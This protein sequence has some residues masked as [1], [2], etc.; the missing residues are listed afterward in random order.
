MPD[1]RRLR[2]EE[3]LVSALALLQ[4]TGVVANARW[5][6]YLAIIAYF[7]FT[8]GVGVFLRNKMQSSE[9]YFLSDR[10][11]PSW[12]TGLAFVGANLG[13][14]E[15]LGNGPGLRSTGSCRPTSSGSAPYPR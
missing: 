14:V 1:R 11:L 2:K 13:A 7:A 3:V 8:V 12:V 10:S 4:A 5:L 9:D 6:D 15:I